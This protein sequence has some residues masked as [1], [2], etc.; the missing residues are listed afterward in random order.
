VLAG[1]PELKFRLH[2]SSL[3]AAPELKFRLH[4]SSPARD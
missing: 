4:I 3:A 2:I 1:P